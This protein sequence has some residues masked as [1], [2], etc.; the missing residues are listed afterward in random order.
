MFQRSLPRGWGMEHDIFIC[1]L[2]NAGFSIR[3][4]VY[5]IRLYFPEFQAEPLKEEQLDCRMRVLD[6]RYNDYW[7]RDVSEWSWAKT[8]LSEQRARGP[9]GYR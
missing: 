9:R 3:S 1:Q 6:E 5:K 4:I 2:D 8:F 7:S